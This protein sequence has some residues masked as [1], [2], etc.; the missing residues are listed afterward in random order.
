LNS[1]LKQKKKEL[2]KRNK[3]KEILDRVD[4]LN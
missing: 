3:T 1:D 2:K 4:E